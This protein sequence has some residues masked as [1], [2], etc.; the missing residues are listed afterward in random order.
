MDELV[1][2]KW[3]A[4]AATCCV[5]CLFQIP[6]I[7]RVRLTIGNVQGAVVHAVGCAA[8]YE[9]GIASIRRTEC[10]AGPYS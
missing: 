3:R 6:V 10:L 7:G 9:G 2:A 8:G 4:D 1:E 5:S